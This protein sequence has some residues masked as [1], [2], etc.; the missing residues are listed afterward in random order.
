MGSA[1]KNVRWHEVI[2]LVLN[3]KP[4]L[5][6]Q[7]YHDTSFNEFNRFIRGDYHMGYYDAEIHIQDVNPL[8]ANIFKCG[9]VY[10]T[11]PKDRKAPLYFAP[12][13]TK[14][15]SNTREFL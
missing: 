4:S 8:N 5:P 11:S 10:V 3:H 2:E 15:G 9:W 7:R 14:Q 1:F 13:F 6:T 12:Y